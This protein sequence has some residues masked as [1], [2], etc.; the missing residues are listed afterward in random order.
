MNKIILSIAILSI[1]PLGL[2]NLSYAEG[3]PKLIPSIEKVVITKDT[4]IWFNEWDNPTVKFHLF[5][6]GNETAKNVNIIFANLTISEINAKT[7]NEVILDHKENPVTFNVQNVTE[8]TK[9][10][11]I[12]ITVNTDIE[13]SSTYSGKLVA[14]GE[15]FEPVTIKFDYV[16]KHNA[17]D[18]VAFTIIGLLIAI[19]IGIGVA[20]YQR[21]NSP[22]SFRSNKK[23]II[24]INGHI[25]SANLVRAYVDDDIWKMINILNESKRKKIIKLYNDG[26]KLSNDLEEI[27]W[28]ENDLK[29]IVNKILTDKT[30][31]KNNAGGTLPAKDKLNFITELKKCKHIIPG[32]QD[33]DDVNV[34]LPVNDVPISGKCS[35]TEKIYSAKDD[36]FDF[37]YVVI[38]IGAGI[39]SIPL[40]LFA[41]DYFMGEPLTDVLIALGVGFIVYRSQDISKIMKSKE[42]EEK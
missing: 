27:S 8:F 13:T 29:N 31:K 30:Y 15:N 17:W 26:K 38:R 6:A 11:P 24:H 35:F 9:S 32:I 37:K 34:D 21:Y 20:V 19:A 36:L 16:I 40:T 28:Y 33:G 23:F 5:N 25:Q 2:S 7:I 12:S 10:D 18:L 1:L 14:Y 42:K 41:S 22:T 3:G 39:V 4:G